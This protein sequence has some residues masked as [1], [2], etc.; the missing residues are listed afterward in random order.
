MDISN[1]FPSV[2]RQVV[3]D[4]WQRCFDFPP[5]VA[6]LLARLTTHQEVLPQGAPTSPGLGNLVFWDCEGAVVENIR[7]LG[8]VYTR[9]VDDVVV[10][11]QE[12]VEMPDLEPIFTQVFG[13]FRSK[14][15]RPNRHKIDI[16]TSGHNMQVHNLNVNGA[17]PSI[18]KDERR[19]IRAAVRAC[20]NGPCLAGID[21]I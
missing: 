3:Q 20:V 2:T 1:F 6:R 21:R 17:E 18:P 12:F 7:E 4:T 11:S 14:G 5:P 8:F 16:S 9:F 13:M 19:R 15:V 10:S